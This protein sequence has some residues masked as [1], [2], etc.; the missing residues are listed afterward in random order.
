MDAHFEQPIWQ[1]L[2]G[3]AVLNVE[4]AR[5]IDGEDHLVK[6]TMVLD[7]QVLLVGLDERAV[8]EMAL[9]LEDVHIIKDGLGLHFWR[10]EALAEEAS[11]RTLRIGF[12]IVPRCKPRPII[13][14]LVSLAHCII[15]EV[16]LLDLRRALHSELWQ[17][18]VDRE[19]LYQPAFRHPLADLQCAQ[20]IFA[21]AQ[22]FAVLDGYHHCADHLPVAL[23]PRWVLPAYLSPKHRCPM[24]DLERVRVIDFNFVRDIRAADNSSIVSESGLHEVRAFVEVVV[25]MHAMNIIFIFGKNIIVKL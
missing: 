16:Y 20:Y 5:R 14:L 25:L 18:G 22:V 19:S 2:Q 11:D 1:L 17:L 7:R 9:V 8:E 21:L 15:L 12:V 23:P 4:R 24:K 10:F 13:S 6:L 3:K